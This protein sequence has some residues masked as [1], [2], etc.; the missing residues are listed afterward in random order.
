MPAL[1]QTDRNGVAKFYFNSVLVRWLIQLLVAAHG[2]GI[3]T[4]LTFTRP[5]QLRTRIPT[6]EIVSGDN[7]RSEKWEV[8]TDPLVVIVKKSNG[9][10]SP[11]SSLVSP[12]PGY[13]NK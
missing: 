13:F 10:Q 3:D 8:L 1:Y 2:I 4:T 6:L 9:T 12:Q 5:H 7:Q 11:R